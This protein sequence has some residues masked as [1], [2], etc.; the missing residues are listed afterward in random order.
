MKALIR[1]YSRLIREKPEKFEDLSK[2]IVRARMPITTQRYLA[3]AFV[4]S[5]VSAMVGVVLG[6][7]I[8]TI[9][10]PF[11]KVTPLIA[12][13]IPPEI[14]IRNFKILSIVYVALGA[15]LLGIISFKFV[16][17][18]VLTYPFFIAAK[19]KNEIDLYLPHAVNMMFGMAVGGV[20]VYDIIKCI[21]E[22]KVMCGELS[23]E[24][25]IIVDLVENFKHDLFDSMRFVRD[26][27]PSEKLAA[28]LDDLIFVMSSGGRLT[29]FLRGKSEELLEEQEVSFESYIDFLGIMAEVYI[30]IFVLLPLFLLIVLVV[31][32]LIGENVINLYRLAIAFVLPVATVAFVYLIKSSL[33]TPKVKIE[34]ELEEVEKPIVGV[35]SGRAET[36]E[37]DK[38]RRLLKKLKK[39]VVYPFKEKTIYTLQ[40]RILSFHFALI[41]IITFAVA[42][43]FLNLE[44]SL[45]LTVSAV[46]I[47]LI[48]LV[49]LRGRTIKKIEEKIPNLFRELAVLNEAELNILEALNVISSS[50][51]GIISKEINVVRRRIEWGTTI[52]R[53]FA[54]LGVRIK[55][56]LIAKI[57]PIITK[58]LEVSP[59]FKDAFITVARYADSEVRFSKRIRN[60]MFTYII[61]TYM[62]IFIFLFVVYI[63]IKSFLSAFAVNTTAMGSITF[64]MNIDT[65]KEVFFEISLMVGLFSGIIAGVIGEGKIESGLK[66]SY[67]FLMATYIVFKILL[68]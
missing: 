17:Y 67:V 29:E 24:F 48:I 44:R 22:S 60:Y 13:I 33:P 65:I 27:T 38:F 34:E 39:I 62:S 31:M 61:I 45:I 21:A 63:V 68:R 2:A 50:E 51:I 35:R 53:A 47:P 49:E 55:S 25:R 41:A 64:T 40:F 18:L 3:L 28:F 56:D 32:Q 16:H 11:G 6:I 7:L 26:T 15:S 30:A 66:H 20:R 36:F 5:A 1:R 8:F 14:I 42:S 37:I 43:K 12:R 9:L 4:Y 52:H 54:V 23:R 19:R 59:T 57:I 10:I 58:A 46:A